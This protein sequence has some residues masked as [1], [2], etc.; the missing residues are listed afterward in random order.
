LTAR[1]GIDFNYTAV[2]DDFVYFGDEAVDQ[3][4]MTALFE[5]GYNMAISDDLWQKRIPGLRK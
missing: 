2:P 4:E 1:D 5:L 3:E